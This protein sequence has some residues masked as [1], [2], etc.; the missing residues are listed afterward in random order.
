MSD[1][2]PA[3]LFSPAE[4]GLLRVTVLVG[5]GV[6]LASLV[7][8][9]VWVLAKLVATFYG[10]LLPLSVAGVI[11]LVLSPVVDSMEQRFGFG[12]LPAVILLFA[13]FFFAAA[14]TLMVVLPA[15]VAQ[16]AQFFDDAPD[17]FSRW[18]N[19]FVARFPDIAAMITA[20]M[21]EDHLRD[22]LPEMEDATDRVMRY[23]ETLVGLAFVPLFLFFAL[24]SGRRMQRPFLE[25]LQV[26]REDRRKEIVYLGSVFIDYV[27]GFFR[28][29]LIIAMIMGILLALGFTLAG[30]QAAIPF[31]LFLGLLNIVPFLGIIVGLILVL[32]VAYLQPGGGAELVAWV[33]LVFALVQLIESWLLTPKIMAD[34]SGLH[35]ALGVISIFF[36]GTA[37]GGIIGMILAVP[38][39]AFIITLWRHLTHRYMSHVMIDDQTADTVYRPPRPD[40]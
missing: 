6:V 37:L 28:G 15:T 14:L 27:T 34:R 30:L 38:L 36:W 19:Q 2:G 35:P 8:F 33:L 16:L 32:P 40:T 23:L 21:E 13:V 18:H 4:R 11:A 12:R 20:R 7:V 39:T 25:A 1:H 26:L 31:G 9:I 29:Q 22:L 10:I 24:L 3:G 17:T 5:A